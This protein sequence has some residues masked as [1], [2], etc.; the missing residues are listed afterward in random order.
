[1]GT[2]NNTIRRTLNA[3]RKLPAAIVIGMIAFF[4]LCFTARADG[5]WS[6][7]RADSRCA[8]LSSKPAGRKRHSSRASSIPAGKSLSRNGAGVF[9]S[10]PSA[11][12]FMRLIIIIAIAVLIIAGVLLS[13]EPST[14]EQSF[15]RLEDGPERSLNL[16]DS[17]MGTEAPSS[18]IGRAEKAAVVGCFISSV[19]IIGCI[20]LNALRKES[21][22]GKE[23]PSER[24][25]PKEA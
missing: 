3:A 22:H 23:R 20:Y 17:G 19:M 13:I 2:R 11:P 6:M 10:P 1:M 25:G 9:H 8:V 16:A 14:D 12:N 24:F 15:H 4:E 21:Q 7:A 5:A 18:K